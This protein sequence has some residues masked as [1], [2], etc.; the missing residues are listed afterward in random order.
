MMQKTLLAAMAIFLFLPNLFNKDIQTPPSYNKKEKF[1]SQLA[2][3]SSIPQLEKYIDSIAAN[4]NI[5]IN[6]FE[7][8]ELIESVVKDRFYHGFSHFSLSEN[9]IAAVCGKWIQD[10]LGC[11]VQPGDIMQHSYAACSQQSIVI[12]ALLRHKNIPYRKV[13]FP[14]HYA[15]ESFV[16]NNWYFIDAD[17]EPV[18][19]K[20]ERQLS[21]W[22]H[23]NDQLKKYYDTNH[24]SDLDYK[25]GSGV[26]AVNGPINEI[27]ASHVKIFHAVTFVL[28]KILWCF[29]FLLIFFKT[30]FSFRP[31]FALSIKRRNAVPASLAV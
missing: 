5:S 7:Y 12:M 25:F 20:E 2:Y 6:S 31:S 30:K 26:I 8:T 28:S 13:A 24:F 1:N 29:P 14:H 11:K 19:A 21:H 9:W 4:K 15:V 16:N 17:M 27:P 22:N 10:G 18:I 23:Q 3:I